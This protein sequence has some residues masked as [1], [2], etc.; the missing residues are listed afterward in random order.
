MVSIFN[1]AIQ[2]AIAAMIH[3]VFAMLNLGIVAPIFLGSAAV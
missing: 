2:S 3:N 1:V